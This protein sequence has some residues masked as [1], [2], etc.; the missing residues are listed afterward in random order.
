MPQLLRDDWPTHMLVL[1]SVFADGDSSLTGEARRVLDARLQSDC[2][3][4]FICSSFTAAVYDAMRG[5][6]QTARMV[7]NRLRSPRASCWANA[8]SMCGGFALILDA[9]LA[10]HES[11]PDA[12]AR[13]VQLDS[14]LRD[15]PVQVG[16]LL[17]VG[18]LVAARL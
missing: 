3:A 12:R 13:L 2:V 1:E 7:V 4:P 14:M 18:N 16:P 11:R 10:A 17:H 6:P 8:P 15:A 5:N 9:L